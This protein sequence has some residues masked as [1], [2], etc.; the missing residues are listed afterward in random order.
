MLNIR[1]CTWRDTVSESRPWQVEWICRG[2]SAIG[3][4]SS[5]GSESGALAGQPRVPNALD[6]DVDI[7]GIRALN[8]CRA[9]TPLPP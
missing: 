9:H 4:R 1:P 2:P 5:S 8:S 7:Y 6:R 3:L